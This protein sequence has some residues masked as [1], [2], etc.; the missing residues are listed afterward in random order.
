MC[1]YTVYCVVQSLG[2]GF[3][4]ESGIE[5]VIEDINSGFPWPYLWK[6]GKTWICRNY[7]GDNNYVLLSAVKRGDMKPK[8]LGCYRNRGLK[9]SE[10]S[11]R[12]TIHENTNLGLIY[13]LPVQDPYKYLRYYY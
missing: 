9:V 11:C 6:L 13:K 10:A 7:T 5:L 8:G 3:P 1:S 12:V 2:K 4:E